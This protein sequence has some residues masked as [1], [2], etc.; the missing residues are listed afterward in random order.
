MQASRMEVEA[1]V[2]SEGEEGVAG[3]SSQGGG[4]FNAG[5]AAGCWPIGE[6]ISPGN[7]SLEDGH[8]GTGLDLS[9]AFEHI[10]SLG[11][12]SADGRGDETAGPGM[13]EGDPRAAEVKFACR[14]DEGRDRE[15]ARDFA[16]RPR[17]RWGK[18]SLR[19]CAWRGGVDFGSG[20]GDK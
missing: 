12:N 15:G 18:P 7:A 8:D 3:R 10:G 5:S 9:E 17:E 16:G 6:G 1:R 2:E 19:W 20:V 4:G 13:C 14:Q 11:R